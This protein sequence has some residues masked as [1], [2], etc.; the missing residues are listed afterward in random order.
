MEGVVSIPKVELHCHL[1]G[2]IS[3]RLL[4]TL[5]IEG[6]DVL[7]EPDDLARTL[8]IRTSRDFT[9]WLD[10]MKP[11]Q[12]ASYKHY[13]PI[14]RAHLAHLARQKVIYTELMVSPLMLP[15][16]RP[17]QH[18]AL[19]QLRAVCEES[20]VETALLMVLPRSLAK[21]KAIADM[22]QFLEMWQHK[23]IAGV[24]V[25]GLET[26]APLDNL[27]GALR[28]A[29]A[30]GMGIEIHAGEHGHTDAVHEAIFKGGAARIG[31][32]LA[33]FNDPSLLSVIAERGIHLEFCLTSNIK[34]QAI[35]ELSDH[36]ITRA[37]ELGLSFSLNT[38]DPGA[39][40]C[41][42]SDEFRLAEELF[43]FDHA[44]FNAIYAQAWNARFSP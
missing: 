17:A 9:R 5:Q 15:K 24:A 36:P 10:V 42:L 1:I 41:N 4:R 33:A 19:R 26:G 30:A 43:G 39:F 32:G 3:P 8:P 2:T 34:T 16:D 31:H 27:L 23:L 7:V 25:V 40:E 18:N 28:M 38:D 20:T 44:T 21:H 6:Y 35:S 22:H 14:L 29:Q 37:A 12:S 13:I 11:Y